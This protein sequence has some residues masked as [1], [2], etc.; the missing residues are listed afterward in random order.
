[1]SRR[2]PSPKK[3]QRERT[4]AAVRLRRTITQTQ[5]KYGMY[6]VV[7]VIADYLDELYG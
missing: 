4:L 2:L 1:M 3:F 7:P 6:T 5:T